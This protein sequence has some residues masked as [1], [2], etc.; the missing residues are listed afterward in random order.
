M[1]KKNDS[2]IPLKASTKAGAFI[3]SALL[4]ASTVFL[5]V[6]SFIDKD[7]DISKNENRALKQKPKFSASELFAGKLTT[8]FDEYYSD[9][10]PF[11]EFFVSVSLKAKELLTQY[12]GKDDV[13]ILDG[14]GKDDFKGEEGSD[15]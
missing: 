9:Q 14:A 6:F 5:G 1:K 10:F 4:I 8:E 7:K 11:R 3:I 13:V 12:G 15:G 2:F